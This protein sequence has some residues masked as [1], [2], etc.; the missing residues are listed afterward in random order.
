[1]ARLRYIFALGC[2]VIALYLGATWFFFGSPHPCGILEAI[3]KPYAIDAAQKSWL[4]GLKTWTETMKETR[5]DSSAVDA[6]TKHFES[7]SQQERAAVEM[8]H[9]RISH[10]TPA[11]CLWEVVTRKPRPSD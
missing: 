3:Q 9:W 8:L 1:M 5:F 11:Q 6:F 2:A 10:K 7:R 4:E